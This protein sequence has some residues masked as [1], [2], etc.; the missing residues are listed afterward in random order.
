MKREQYEKPK[1]LLK[2]REVEAYLSKHWGVILHKLPISYRLD[3]AIECP[4]NNEIVGVVEVK[5][6]DMTYGQY[7]TVIVSLSKWL[8]GRRYHEAGLCFYFFLNLNDGIYGTLYRPQFSYS[9]KWGGRTTKTRD[10]ADIEPVVH[11]P[12]THFVGLPK[13][14]WR[15]EYKE[16]DISL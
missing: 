3:Y 8:M 5:A 10:I 4:I 12:M 6:R 14:G 11:I 2:E 16:K 13:R 15:Y 9:V 1:D 7:P